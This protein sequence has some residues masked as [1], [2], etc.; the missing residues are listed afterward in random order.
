MIAAAKQVQAER[1]ASGELDVKRREIEFLVGRSDDLK[2]VADGSVDIVLSGE[3]H[4][5]QA[6][7]PD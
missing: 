2:D 3:F 1:R 7:D 4:A 5:F 6:D